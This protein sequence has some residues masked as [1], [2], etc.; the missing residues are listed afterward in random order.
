MK[1]T[2]STSANA[3]IGILFV[4]LIWGVEFVLIHNAIQILEPHSF[5]V[6]RFGLAA[7]TMAVYLGGKTLFSS[8]KTTSQSATASSNRML[9]LRGAI[10]GLILYLAFTLQTFGLLY[11]SVSNSSFITSLNTTLVPVFAFIL[12]K[13]RPHWLTIGGVTIATLGLYFLTSGGDAPFNLGDGLTFLCAIM[14]ALHIIFT[15]KHSRNHAT[16]PLTVVQLTTVAI[17][18]LFS[19]L[20]FEDWRQMLNVNLLFEPTLLFAIVFVAF[21]GTAVAITVQT[22][23]QGYLSETRVA[24]IFA[25][26]PVFAAIS[27][28]IV[29]GETL[30]AAAGFGAV[31]ILCGV[32]LAQLPPATVE[33]ATTAKETKAIV[34][35]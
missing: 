19:A 15:G 18:S 23:A 4:C 22:K 33:E 17:L 6:L 34:E 11:T 12:L 24:L 32:I 35:G 30:P 14:F 21:L 26:E 31:M 25:L 3:T 16:L 7:L 13:D 2:L 29:L 27:A 20:F 9:I 5:N 10:L 8:A 28:Y 1:S